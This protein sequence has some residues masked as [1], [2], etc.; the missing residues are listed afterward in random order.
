MDQ[1]MGEFPKGHNPVTNA[2]RIAYN[3]YL[4]V[5]EIKNRR[6][7]HK[8]SKTFFPGPM[9]DRS[10]VILPRDVCYTSRRSPEQLQ[11]DRPYVLSVLNGAYIYEGTDKEGTDKWL[12]I[13]DDIE[14]AGFAGGQGAQIDSNGVDSDRDLA[15][16]IGGTLTV[17]NTGDMRI[18]N[19]DWILWE[20]PPLNKPYEKGLRGSERIVLHIRPYCGRLD[21]MSE[22]LFMELMRSANP[23]EFETT[24]RSHNQPI[25]EGALNVRN[26]VYE[27]MLMGIHIALKL[28]IVG[29]KV[30]GNGGTLE[31]SKY[32][33]SEEA[34]NTILSG[35]SSELGLI[36]KSANGKV[37]TYKVLKKEVELEE[38]AR[39]TM[40][41]DHDY[42]MFSMLSDTGTLPNGSKGQIIK[43][44]KQMLT[45][46]INGVGSANFHTTRRII[47]KAMNSGNP[48]EE[49]D[50]LIN[51]YMA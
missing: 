20:L 37:K 47:G 49:L 7:L 44:Q 31:Q 42:L 19:G 25:V 2:G 9:D 22:N 46:L 38:V 45:D 39:K 23:A 16:V 28:G 26:A 48:G 1:Y 27:C 41:G 4:D 34:R 36:K 13:L 3:A 17:P 30:N 10:L 11:S 6:A 43:N 51:R 14:F 24:S 8:E 18:N 15:L 12:T 35:I 40:V 50:I 21:R 29:F 32:N 5:E 33:G